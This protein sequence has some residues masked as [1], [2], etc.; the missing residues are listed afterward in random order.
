MKILKNYLSL[1]VLLLC[2]TMI[3]Q[4]KIISFENVNVIPMNTDTIITNQRV[5]VANGKIS[6]IE[7]TTKAITNHIDVT[8]EA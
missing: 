8:I 7:P 5:I 1:Y 3:A 2:S 6:K 4:T